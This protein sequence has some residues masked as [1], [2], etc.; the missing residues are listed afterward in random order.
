MTKRVNVGTSKAHIP[1]ECKVSGSCEED[2]EENL[3][4]SHKRETRPGGDHEPMGHR[5]TPSKISGVKREAESIYRRRSEDRTGSNITVEVEHSHGR[6]PSSGDC[7]G[8]AKRQRSCVVNAHLEVDGTGAR[9]DSYPGMGSGAENHEGGR[10]GA[11]AGGGIGVR[12]SQERCVP[13]RMTDNLDILTRV[14]SFYI[15]FRSIDMDAISEVMAVSQAWKKACSSTALWS[16][17]PWELESGAMNWGRFENMGKKVE[18]TEGVCFQCR[19]RGTNQIYAMKKARVYP[20]GEGV[21]YYMLRELAVLKGVDHPN[22]S[23]LCH[24]NLHKF[25]LRAFFPY[26]PHT[27]HDYIN[28][29][30]DRN[31]GTP[32]DHE[33]AR[34]LLRQLLRAVSYCHR[35]GVLHRNL[36]PK[37]LLILPGDGPDRLKGATLKLSD[38]ALVRLAGY[39]R[40]T[41]TNEVV[42]LWYR[43]PEILMGVRDYSPAVDMW[44]VGCIFV[45]MLQGKPLFTGV[46]QID[47]LFQMFN[48]LATPT[49]ETW[50]GFRDLPN[51]SFAF[52]NWPRR[53]LSNILPGFDCAGLDLIGCFLMYDPAKRITAHE[54]LRHPY[55]QVPVTVDLMSSPHLPSA[56]DTKALAPQEPLP[57]APPGTS[58][59][60]RLFMAHLRAQEDELCPLRDYLEGQ[61]FRADHRSMLVDWLMEVVDVFDM[62]QRTAFLAVNYTDRFLHRSVIP[63]SDF[64]L[65][66]ATSLHIASKT[67]DVSYIGIED[68]ANCAGD[69]YQPRQVLDMEENVL[70]TLEFQLAVPTTV[71]FL[72]VMLEMAPELGGMESELGWLSLYMAE[73]SLQEYGFVLCKPSVTAASCLV[74][75]LATV[76]LPHWPEAL[77]QAAGH[78]LSALEHCVRRLHGLHRAMSMSHLEVIYKRFLKAERREVARIV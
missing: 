2:R 37:H 77:R 44:S 23:S 68:L 12:S 3:V 57:G 59:N 42:T 54:A 52:P 13:D 10:R 16:T 22:V 7:S 60:I 6:T 65:L 31:G 27:L 4:D 55:L 61:A 15:G 53:N 45:E 26:I 43:P 73:I 34:N 29:T 30:N 17:A 38:F 18:G 36:K 50:P 28:P 64:Q 9:R 8:G 72:H 46:S 33:T 56:A 63:R 20:R 35:R 41:Y 24:V 40:R 76:G 11:G 66:G 67:E 75:A 70:N 74:L 69:V 21:P 47:Q 48:K 62:C 39:P 71:D 19:D 1:A 14:L 25:K 78:P 32:L 51:F 49:S 58:E 5:C